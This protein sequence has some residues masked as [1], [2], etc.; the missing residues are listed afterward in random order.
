MLAN[1]N[2]G[3]SECR[4]L[5]IEDDTTSGGGIQVA[6]EGDVVRHNKHVGDRASSRTRRRR[7]WK[8]TRGTR[9]NRGEAGGSCGSAS[10]IDTLAHLYQ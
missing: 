3:K 10:F 1:R 5:T 2:S 9:S 7:S 8:E 6:A 4:N